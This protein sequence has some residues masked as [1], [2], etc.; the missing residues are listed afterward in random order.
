MNA[1]VKEFRNINFEL[2]AEK[3]SLEKYL[4]DSESSSLDSRTIKKIYAR[5]KIELP[6]IV[7]RTLDEVEKFYKSIYEDRIIQI[8]TRLEKINAAVN[9][10][11]AIIENLETQLDS[12]SKILATNDAYENSLEILYHLNNELQALKFRQGQLDQAARYIKEENAVNSD[13]LTEFSLFENIK[14]E[15]EE[16]L[17][18]YKNFVYELVDKIYG[19]GVR[20]SFDMQFS[21]YD[22]KKRPISISMEI[23]GDA[24]EGV[25]EVKKVIIDFLLFSFN[26]LL[27]IFIHDSSCYNGVDPRQVS[28]LLKELVMMAEK[29]QKQVIVSINKYQLADDEFTTFVYNH[30]AIVLSET[31]KLLGI[32]F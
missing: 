27:E 7:L 11:N 4:K 1:K 28:G 22:K 10:N 19:K 24:G 32:D 16:T 25:K 3:D 21:K 12:K 9:E 31:D 13:L 5:A 30:S 20:A 18:S 6:D 14:G 15:I 26:N 8:K 2:L 17:K 29:N 23:T